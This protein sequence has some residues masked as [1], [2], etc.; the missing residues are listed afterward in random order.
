MDS[1]ERAILH[2]GPPAYTAR[3][4]VCYLADTRCGWVRDYSNERVTTWQ[5]KM[6]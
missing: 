5:S 3:L 4:P 6:C 1:K 2:H